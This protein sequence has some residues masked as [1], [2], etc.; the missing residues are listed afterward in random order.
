MQTGGL[1]LGD[2]L[3]A[4]GYSFEFAAL[5]SLPEPIARGEPAR[6]VYLYF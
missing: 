2:A 1:P 6:V 5:E 3:T 4:L